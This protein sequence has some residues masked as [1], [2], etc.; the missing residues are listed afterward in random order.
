MKKVICIMGPTGAGKTA[1]AI[2]LAKAGYPIHVINSDSRQ[3]YYDFP[4]ISAQP[5]EKEKAACPHELYGYLQS[6]EK[7]S[8]GEWIKLAKERIDSA[9]NEG[10]IPVLVGGTGLYFRTLFDGMA[11]IPQIPEHIHQKYIEELATHGS[12]YLHN[13]LKTIDPDY[14][15]KIHFND[16]QRVARALEVFEATG[17]T[18]TSW[19]TEHAAQIE[20][21]G[22]VIQ[23]EQSNYDVLRVGIGI[24]LAELTPILCK[25]TQIMFE[26]GAL[27][28]AKKALQKCPDLNAPAWTGIGC[29][30]LALYLQK[31][32]TLDACMEAWNKNTR[33]Y[34][35][36]QWTWF[37]ADKR[38]T[39]FRPEEDSLNFMRE[40]LG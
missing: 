10:C 33:A 39:W 17:K 23:T 30:E 15:Q 37:N 5:N 21:S 34:A 4:I 13:K 11:N 12:E 18:F 3:V 29:R 38:I 22:Q 32:Y 25:R 8:A 16:K 28:E 14:A 31:K 1:S 9:H 24:P 6:H 36:R 26:R 7:N 19:H 40:F 35:K 27:E 20:Q 2:N